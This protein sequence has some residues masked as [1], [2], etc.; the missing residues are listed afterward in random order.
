MEFEKFTERSRGFV[1]SAQALALREGHQRFTPEHLLKV[2]LD[3]EEGLAAN[4]IQAAG[5][6][7]RLALRDIEA[8]L[9][10][11]P[12]VSG[13]GAG[14]VYLSPTLV[15]FA[16]IATT[17]DSGSWPT[18]AQAVNNGLQGDGDLLG[19]LV[20]SYIGSFSPSL[21]L[22]VNCIGSVR[23]NRPSG[24]HA[25]DGFH[26]R[27][28]VCFVTPNVRHERLAEGKSAR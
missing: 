12:K 1:Q 11:M 17:Y 24:V 28:R 4:L 23:A 14:Q 3:D 21:N 15:N 13:G 6:D 8:A 27:L 25:F 5:G 2:L 20:S 26:V 22:A 10:K 18:L 7:S 9:E 16:V 19:Q